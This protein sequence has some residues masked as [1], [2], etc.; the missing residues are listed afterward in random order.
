MSAPK[1][2]TPPSRPRGMARLKRLETELRLFF[3][4][5]SQI[6]ACDELGPALAVTLR[7]ICQAA[8]WPLG[9][10]WMPRRS[11]GAEV[12]E[13]F[14]VSYASNANAE[15]FRAASARITFARGEGL[16]GRAS[17]QQSPMWMTGIDADPA[18]QRALIAKKLG[19]KSALALPIVTGGQL[20]AVAEFLM[21]RRHAADLTFAEIAGDLTAHV[22]G[23]LR[24]IAA[25]SALRQS[26]QRF[27]SFMQHL[28]AAALIRDAD[29]R[30]MFVNAFIERT[31]RRPLKDWLG[32][33]DA[34][35]GTPD[36]GDIR[37]TDR[38]VL[39]EG[40]PLSRM[41]QVGVRDPRYWIATKFPLA[42]DSQSPPMLGAISLEITDQKRA[43]QLAREGEQRLRLLIDNAR[44]YAI[45]TLDPNGAVTSWNQ[46]AVRL[47][48]YS[49]E[50]VIGK[51]FSCFYTPEDLVAEKPQ[52][53]LATASAEGRVED[54][55][56]R[57]RKDGSRFWAS[58]VI[59]SIRDDAGALL[60]F[61]KI[62]RDLTERRRAED[63]R[64]LLAQTGEALRVRDEI[65]SF[66]SHEM[67]TPLASLNLQLEMLRRDRN[68]LSAPNQKEILE[69]MDRAYARMVEL[70]ESFLQY[71]RLQGRIILKTESVDLN[72]LATEVVEELRPQAQRK[73]IGLVLKPAGGA[74][75]IESDQRFLRLILVNLIGNAIKFSD[76][77]NVE[78]SL[79]AQDGER[80]VAVR[81][82]GPGIAIA[83]QMRIFEPFE[84]GEAISN[85]HIPGVGLG[86]ALVKRMS[87]AIGAKIELES[88]LGAGSTF[89][90]VM[91]EVEARRKGS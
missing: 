39:D 44:D 69:R 68:A 40:K 46:G 53:L 47:K 63:D 86:L 49:A 32:K 66:A 34:D 19:F 56:W 51:H 42:G 28:P 62:T 73:G 72:A 45:Y 8:A 25:E 90:L 54:E 18:F 17:A 87:D 79:A 31:T 52:R 77:G 11:N 88:Q 6:A 55:G 1:T 83:D 35:L 5:S 84:R 80:R 82:H 38:K 75:S 13:L 21:E 36:V 58:A 30:Y 59:N 65:L 64:V 50:E 78:V 33:T 23:Q 24:R 7:E 37:A 76:R 61:A 70:V 15:Q 71:S 16:I 43:E 91:R 9:Q 10:I 41:L 3:T 89:T 74:C 14:P 57:V 29:G 22:G 67:R 81:D 4:V 2:V 48:G 27:A 20:F 26:E 12:L 60:G 85:K